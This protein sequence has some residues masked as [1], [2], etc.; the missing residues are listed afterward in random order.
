MRNYFVIVVL[1][2][3]VPA[4]LVLLLFGGCGVGHLVTGR[5]MEQVSMRVQTAEQVQ[6]DEQ[7]CH[8]EAQEAAHDSRQLEAEGGRHR[9]LPVGAPGQQHVLGALGEVGEGGQD[10]R[11]LA[12]EDLVGPADLEELAGLGDVLGGGAPVHVAARVALAGPIEL[13]HQRHERMPGAGQTLAHRAEIQEGQVRLADDLSGR[14][15]RDDPELGLGP[16]QGS[17]DI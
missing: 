14:R 17:L 3:A 8:V 7:E 10:R 4:T 6:A 13:P 1:G 5:M 9:V 16:G 11:E 15:L 12:Q 2:R